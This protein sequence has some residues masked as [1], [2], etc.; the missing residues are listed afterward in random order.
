MTK[1]MRKTMVTMMMVFAAMLLMVAPVQ[2][3]SKTKTTKVTLKAGQSKTLRVKTAGK[4][5]WS[6]SNKAIV[7]VNKKGKIVARRAGKAKITAKYG[8]KKAVFV[9]TVK[10]TPCITSS[11][12]KENET[13]YRVDRTEWGADGSS[14][15]SSY[16]Y[17]S[18]SKVW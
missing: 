10:N 5:K 6:S 1:K 17:Y 11:I 12:R 15:T 4:V 8:K 2:A 16:Y 7:S 3:A 13:M 14:S 18:W 9:V